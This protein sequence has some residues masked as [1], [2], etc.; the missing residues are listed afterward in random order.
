MFSPQDRVLVAVSGG[1]DSLAL[2]DVLWKLNYKVDGLYIGVGIDGGIS[3]SDESRIYCDK[4]A[5]E[6][7]LNLHIVE[8]TQE[9]NNTIPQLAK[10]SARGKGKPCSVCGF[11]KRY[12]MNRVAADGKYDVIVTGHNLDDEAATLFGNTLNWATGYLE[13]QSPILESTHPGLIRK[14][15]PFCRLYERESAAYAIL[16][17]IKY[18]YNECPYAIGAKSIKHKK[19]L[20]Q[21]EMD[22]P[23]AKLSFYLSFLKAENDGFF[24][25]RGE[26]TT[27]NLKTCTACSGPTTLSGECAF[28]RMVA[29]VTE[30]IP[31]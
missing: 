24:T 21:L 16:R 11:T 8:V 1:K 25:K 4:F 18:I 29:K 10:R 6:R 23:R 30:N 13:R 3:Y 19:L 14:A 20:N 27:V 15:K 9:Y 26:T 12:I 28:C 2:W 5:E 22:R 31:E 17:G 7:D